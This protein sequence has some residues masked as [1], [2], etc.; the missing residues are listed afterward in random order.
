MRKTLDNIIRFA[1]DTAQV[2]VQEI[3]HACKDEGAILFLIVVPLLYPLLYSWI[4]NNEVVRD[5]PVAVVDLSHSHESRDFI[6]R[7]D[8]TPDMCVAYHCNSLEE[9][10]SLV[11]QGKAMGVILMPEDYALKMGRMEQTHVS[12]YC[13]TALMLTYKAIFQG[14]NAVAADTGAKIQTR[15]AGNTTS[16]EDELTTRPIDVEEIAMFNTTGGYGNFIL[17][18]VLI[19]IAQQ[20]LLLG[21]G[22]NYG[23][24]YERHGFAPLRPLLDRP[25][26]LTCVM[27]GRTLGYLTLMLPL[28]SWTAL[29]V[30]SLFGL[31]QTIHM[32][33]FITLAVPYLLACIFIAITFSY[34]VRQRE[35]VMLLVVFTSV[36][37]LFMS[38]IS[39]P[40]S[41]V[42]L[43]WKWVSWLFPS[44]F[45]I[46]GFVKLNSMGAVAADITS[47]LRSLWM[48]CLFYAATATIVTW[49][50]IMTWGKA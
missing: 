43:I 36:P 19:L 39:W 5:V 40:Q 42:P 27:T 47:E 37:L 34:A 22:I 26:G 23:R 38:G 3:K 17:P 20:V 6:R 4:Y 41:N 30:P 1:E 28:L 29:A 12:V 9:A 31:V 11:G 48:Q 2:W 10:K 32:R 18:A 16:R 13:N 49:R 45:G 14:C 33:D 50:Q 44:T 25:S 35:N 15:L 21:I 8:A 7:C 24:R 46:Q